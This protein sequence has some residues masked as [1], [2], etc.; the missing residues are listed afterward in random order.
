MVK[1]RVQSRLPGEA[2]L[3]VEEVQVLQMEKE[4]VEKKLLT[5]EP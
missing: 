4:K 5:V 3:L 2:N 1:G